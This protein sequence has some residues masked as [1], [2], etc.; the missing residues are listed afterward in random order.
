LEASVRRDKFG[1][2][3]HAY[4]A[5][6]FWRRL[7]DRHRLAMTIVLFAA[8]S[9]GCTFSDNRRV[10]TEPMHLACATDDDCTYAHLSCSSCGDPVAKRFAARLDD[11]RQ[12]LCKW[13]RG[14]VVDCLPMNPPKC[15][16]DRCSVTPELWD[17]EL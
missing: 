17:P 7:D 9:S 12:R 2:R 4:P 10:R 3:A 14:P 16:I 5:Q 15:K 13:Y 11:E 8:L 6:G 1:L